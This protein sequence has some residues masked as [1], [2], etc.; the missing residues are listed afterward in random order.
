MK[1]FMILV[2]NFH[3]RAHRIAEERRLEWMHNNGLGA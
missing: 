2:L 1:R 3:G